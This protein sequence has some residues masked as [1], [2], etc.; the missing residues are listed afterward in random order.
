MR[1][2]L[3]IKIKKESGT[4]FWCT[5]SAWLFHENVPYSIL[6]QWAK[7]QCHTFFPSQDIKQNVFLS[8]YLDSW[9]CLNFKIDLGSS[10]KAMADRE[11]KR[12]RWK[13]K[14]F[15]YLK[16][17]K[18]FLDEIKNIFHSSWRAII[19]WKIKIC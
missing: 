7:F 5:F 16:N 9:W 13:Y 18:T 8:S 6:Y 2:G 3:F 14:K 15:E 10:S 4:R 12:R 1:F 19:W 11:K 17:E